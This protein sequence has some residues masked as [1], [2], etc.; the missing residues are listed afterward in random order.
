MWRVLGQSVTGTEHSKVGKGCEDSFGW[1]VAG[2]VT[3]LAV[4]DGAGSRDLSAEG[5]RRVVDAVLDRV[6]EAQNPA[7]V[8]SM[9][10]LFDTA[11]ASLVSL[12]TA[13]GHP[14]DDYATTLAVAVLT[15]NG[16]ML[17]QVGDSIVVCRFKDDQYQTVQP[18]ERFEYA[19]ETLFVTSASLSDNLREASFGPGEVTGLAMSTDGLR[20]LILSDVVTCEPFVPFFEDVFDFA[21]QE[22]STSDAVGTFIASLDD[23][24]GDDKTLVVV[25]PGTPTELRSSGPASPPSTPGLAGGAQVE[26]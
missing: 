24:T 9:A 19:N 3:C 20:L 17:G 1:I 23:R 2:D 25:V 21:A 8:P 13:G 10:D 6:A 22:D 15:P 12:A 7:E 11:L 5:S 26:S 4:A 16:V 18:Q 14:V